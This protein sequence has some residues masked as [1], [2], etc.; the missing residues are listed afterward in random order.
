MPYCSPCGDRWFNEWE[1]LEQHRTMSYRHNWCSRCQRDFDSPQDLQDHIDNSAFHYI[2][3]WCNL[4]YNGYDSYMDHMEEQHQQCERCDEWQEGMADLQL[5]RQ[6]Y[7]HYCVMCNR[8]FQSANNLVVHLNS[9]IHKP[10]TYE[11]PFCPR[12]QVTPSAVVSHMESGTCKSGI[13][14]AMMT[15]I[16]P[17]GTAKG[18]SRSNP[19]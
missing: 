3:D 19:R 14:R 12:K 9:S 1:D 4:D 15:T 10:K 7:H 2:C 17:S 18:S 13:T 16:S 6:Q 8:Y 5:H 11:C